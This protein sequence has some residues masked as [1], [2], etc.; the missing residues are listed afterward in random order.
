ME[1]IIE[2]YGIAAMLLLLGAG[3]LAAFGQV[4]QLIVG[5]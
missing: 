4:F 1:Q 2:E 5:V 3:V